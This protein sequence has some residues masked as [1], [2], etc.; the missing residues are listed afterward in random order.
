MTTE[1]GYSHISSANCILYR[2]YY[3]DFE[4]Q[5]YYLNARYY[6]TYTKRFISA[7]NFN[8]L[9]EGEL[10]SYNLYAYCRDNPSMAKKSVNNGS[11]NIIGSSSNLPTI[12][13]EWRQHPSE[14]IWWLY[15]EKTEYGESYAIPVAPD[16]YTSDVVYIAISR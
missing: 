7:D 9:G 15:A 4:T 6:D 13:L 14:V 8:S 11:N 12:L 2:G 10:Q 5:Y 16:Y 3:Y 1:T